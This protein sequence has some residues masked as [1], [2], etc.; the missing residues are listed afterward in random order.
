MRDVC[1]FVGFL[2]QRG[3][4]LESLIQLDLN[5]NVKVLDFW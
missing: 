1:H 3:Y 4:V 5:D 2:T